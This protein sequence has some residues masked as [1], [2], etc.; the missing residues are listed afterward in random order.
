MS[1]AANIKIFQRHRQPEEEAQFLDP[2]VG[3][4]QSCHTVTA[5]GRFDEAFEHVE[6]CGLNPVAE[7]EALRPGGNFSTAGTSQS[8]NWK[9]ASMAGP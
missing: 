5:V 8:R 9:C 4:G 2:E 1:I 6:R 3:L 7:Q